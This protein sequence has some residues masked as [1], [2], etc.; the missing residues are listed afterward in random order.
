MLHLRGKFGLLVSSNCSFRVVIFFDKRQVLATAPAV[1]DVLAADRSTSPYSIAYDER[2]R[3]ILDELI[4]PVANFLNEDVTLTREWH[5]PL[6]NYQ[7]QFNAAA[8]Q[9]TENGLYMMIVADVNDAVSGVTKPAIGDVSVYVET[10][11]RFTDA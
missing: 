5:L 10:D 3:V 2:W 7:M 4:T 8:T 1:G 9:K 6:G 11:V